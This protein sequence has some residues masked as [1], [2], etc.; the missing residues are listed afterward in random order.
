M[1]VWAETFTELLWRANYLQAIMGKGSISVIFIQGTF[2]DVCYN[3]N[4]FGVGSNSG[5]YPCK[6]FFSGK[7]NGKGKF[8]TF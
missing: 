1:E 7:K 4:K 5:G 2:M 3:C 6:H 8:T